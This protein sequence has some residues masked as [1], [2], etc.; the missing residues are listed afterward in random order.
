V[1]IGMKKLTYLVVLICFGGGTCVWA[2]SPGKEIHAIADNLKQNTAA[3]NEYGAT[4]RV[5]TT[6][7]TSDG[8]IKKVEEKTFRT[9]WNGNHA[10]NVLID[11]RCADYESPIRNSNECVEF[12]KSAA[13]KSKKPGKL[14]AE[15]K[16]VRWLELYKNFDFQMLSPDGGFQVLSFQ[17]KAKQIDPE[18]RIEK[19]L[20]HMTGKVW[21][22]DYYNIVK[23][24]AR[25]AEPVSFGLGLAAKVNQVIVR[26][27]QQRYKQV[28]LPAHL[29][30][31]FNAK[32]AL[33]HTERQ[34]IEVTW[35]KPFGR[36][37]GI[38][39]QVGGSL[40]TDTLNER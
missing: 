20:T 17:P 14:D 19:L 28:W 37:E 40:T 33:L 39:A 31:E 8:D 13:E 7:L 32:V 12:T 25:L 15:I 18:N 16:K 26:Y 1:V 22:D 10:S 23:A 34:R 3:A 27:E 6:H 21:V 2:S 30:L 29:N 5:V 11:V 35:K 38:W 4:Q 9:Q 36:S 24:E